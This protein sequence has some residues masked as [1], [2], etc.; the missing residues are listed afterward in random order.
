MRAGPGQN[1]PGRIEWRFAEHQKRRAERALMGEHVGNEGGGE[2]K[3]GERDQRRTQQCD[4]NPLHE[5]MASTDSAGLSRASRGRV[6]LT[7]R[8]R[9]SDAR[10]ACMPPKL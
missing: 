7:S 1:R 9:E 2:P 8:P 3:P 5:R 10:I 4:P 6:M